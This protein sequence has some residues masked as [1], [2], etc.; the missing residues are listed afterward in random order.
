VRGCGLWGCHYHAVW[1]LWSAVFAR[2]LPL[3]ASYELQSRE[4]DLD[5]SRMRLPV[6]QEIRF[7]CLRSPTVEAAI[8]V[9]VDDCLCNAGEA[10]DRSICFEVVQQLE[11]VRHAVSLTCRVKLMGIPASGWVSLWFGQTV[12][13]I[14]NGMESGRPTC[15]DHGASRVSTQDDASTPLHPRLKQD[16]AEESDSAE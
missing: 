14:L 16:S 8:Q 15:A 9:S 11:S 2:E 3:Q 6:R 4:M 7:S 13:L 10:R 1:R 5:T 12:C